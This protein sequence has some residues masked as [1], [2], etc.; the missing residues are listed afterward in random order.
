MVA[1]EGQL[2]PEPE[3]L[4]VRMVAEARQTFGIRAASQL[5]AKLQLPLVPAMFESASQSDLFD[6]VKTI[7][8]SD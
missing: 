7:E 4:R 3:S 8:H 6:R 5:W 1:T 2:N